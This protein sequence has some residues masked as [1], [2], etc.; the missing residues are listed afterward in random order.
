M[1]MKFRTVRNAV[2]ISVAAGLA[3]STA[4]AAARSGSFDKAAP[5]AAPDDRWDFA[6]WD[7]AHHLLLVAHGK[8][9]LVIDPA[10][11]GAVHAIGVLAG[12]HG[13][14]AIPGTTRLLV[15]SGGD[16]SARILDER[17][18]AQLANIAVAGDPDAVILSRDGRTAYAMAA[19]AGAVSVIDLA[20]GVETA[21]IALKPGL[22]V[23]V[24]VSPGML[25]INNEDESEIE[26]AD[27]A[28]GKAAGAIALTGCEG[29]TGLALDPATGLGLSAC[30]NGK[31]ALVDLRRRALVALVP[32]GDGP[33]TAIWDARHSRFLV[34]C[35]R[36][37]TLSIVRMNG[38]RPTVET[39]VGTE[40]SARTAALDPA[41]G[42]V[43]LPAARFGVPVP[44]SKRG[45]MEPGSF[46]IVVMVP[47]G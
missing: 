2:A 36:S 13:V 40:P 14:V 11:L 18:G 24:L 31:A 41:T 7:S 30:A 47:R 23:P 4:L 45:A 39:A 43:Y 37:G 21:R 19:K 27:L 25:A 20:K 5:I 26:F 42:R 44:P 3:A 33:D 32:I 38:R 15:T 46:H 1:P 6:S 9:V 10:S 8:D 34:P 22:E 12:A 28:T 35:G 17:S 29:P 16:D